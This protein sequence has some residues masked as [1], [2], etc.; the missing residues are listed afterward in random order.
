MS[1]VRVREPAMT[2]WR[3]KDTDFFAGGSASARSAFQAQA[4]RLVF[5]GREPVA[6]DGAQVFL[7]EQGRIKLRRLLTDGTTPVYGFCLPGDIFGAIGAAQQADDDRQ[8]ILGTAVGT[9]QVS[10]VPREVFLAL[11]ESVPRLRQ[12]AAA[13][14]GE[15]L[16]QATELASVARM[17]RADVR[18]AVTLLVCARQCG[19]TVEDGVLLDFPMTRQ[20]F[21]DM[22]GVGWHRLTRVFQQF[23]SQGWIRVYQRRLLMIDPVALAQLAGQAQA[24][25]ALGSGMALSWPVPWSVQ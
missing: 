4:Q 16:R 14:M 6:S 24:E 25:I 21:S 15:R 19:R 5:R 12:N 11:L 1:N 9:C 7:L 8:A 18:L 2:L 13:L 17:A 23:E 22:T 20:D 3:R 10:A